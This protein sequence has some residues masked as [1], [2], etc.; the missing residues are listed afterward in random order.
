MLG[1]AITVAAGCILIERA[2]THRSTRSWFAGLIGA[3]L[4]FI[5]LRGRARRIRAR[6]NRAITRRRIEIDPVELASRL[7]FPASDAPAY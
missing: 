5:G 3:E 4:I 1:R 2:I 7:S 6:N